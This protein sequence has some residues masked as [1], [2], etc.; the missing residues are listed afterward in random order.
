[1]TVQVIAII[2]I[3]L[4]YKCYFNNINRNER[5]I[6][7]TNTDFIFIISWNYY[8]L[9]STNNYCIKTIIA[10]IVL[11]NEYDILFYC[12]NV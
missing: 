11:C 4:I 2:N 9:R 6:T 5:N 7:A 3:I 12:R 10:I 1:M 8:G